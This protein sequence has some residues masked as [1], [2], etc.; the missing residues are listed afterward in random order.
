M[1]D[2]DYRYSAFISYRHVE[3]DMSVAKRLHTL[4]ETYRI[5]GAVRASSG[6]KKMGRVFRDQEELPLSSDLGGDITR[7]LEDS[8]WLIV[9]C[10][11]AL[12][13]SKWCMKEIDT[14]I[15][16][17][18]RDHILAVLAS[19]APEES[20]PP[21]LRF[22]EREG[23]VTEVEPLAA[24]IA[25]GGARAMLKKLRGES[26]R[27]LAPMLGVSY[28]DLKQ[29]ARERRLKTVLAASLAAFALLGAF[30]LYAVRQNRIVT[31]Q[32][33]AALTSQSLYLADASL[34]AEESGDHALALLLALEALPEDMAKPDRPVV[35]EAS[36]ALYQLLLAENGLTAGDSEYSSQAIVTTTNEILDCTIIHSADDER[37]L[38][39][40]TNDPASYIQD[41]SIATGARV[42][43]FDNS[44]LSGKPDRTKL[45]ESGS[46]SAFYYGDRVDYIRKD[47]E[48]FTAPLPER[49]AADREYAWELAESK[50]AWS[51]DYELFYRSDGSYQDNAVLLI[52]GDPFRID[53][54]YW[55]Y[56]AVPAATGL[57]EPTYLL[58]GLA[59]GDSLANLV[60]WNAKTRETLRTYELPDTVRGLAA[61]ADG[62]YYLVSCHSF[63]YDRQRDAGSLILGRTQSGE[64]LLT[65]DD[66]ALDGSVAAEL[67]FPQAEEDTYF[68]VVTQDGS[69]MVYDYAAMNWAFIHQAAGYRVLSACWSKDGESILAA[70]SDGCA[71]IVSMAGGVTAELPCA[72]SLERA[73]Y[74]DDDGLILLESFN[75]VQIYAAKEQ[76]SVSSMVITV[77]KPLNDDVSGSAFSP[78]GSLLALLYES[79]LLRVVDPTDGEIVF[80]DE[81]GVG[82]FP[83]YAGSYANMLAFSPDGGALV[84][85]V[86]ESGNEAEDEP[87]TMRVMDTAAWS[88]IRDFTPSYE[89]AAGQSAY[90]N[91]LSI[92]FNADGSLLAAVTQYGSSIV[93]VYDTA[94]WEP[95]WSRG[96]SEKAEEKHGGIEPFGDAVDINTIALFN[97]DGDM[98]LL[99]TYAED[100]DDIVGGSA[101]I[102]VLDAETGSA[103][104]KAPVSGY[105]RIAMKE[106]GSAV[107]WSLDK[108]LWVMAADGTELFATELPNSVDDGG[109]RFSTTEGYVCCTC[110]GSKIAADYIGKTVTDVSAEPTDWNRLNLSSMAVSEYGTLFFSETVNVNGYIYDNSRIEIP[111]GSGSL[112]LFRNQLIDADTG[113]PFLSFGGDGTEVELFAVS[114]D[115]AKLCYRTSDDRDTKILNLP[116][117]TDAISGARERLGGRE[118]SDE[119]MR[120][121]FI[122]Q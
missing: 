59:G 91:S 96:Y 57:D 26:L 15:E 108:R 102:S 34:R 85:P 20:F 10:S 6:K 98:A 58:G 13:E 42:E 117:L 84:Y 101:V 5:P 73:S 113:K 35:K 88:A 51:L 8:E 41:Y 31:E 68:S 114:P 48:A 56:K 99:D 75:A 40:F 47:G 78:D 116:S 89:Y 50:P 105:D 79:G 119:D 55:I 94:T 106:D 64:A 17:G 74:A 69:L 83:Y 37:L 23:R 24:D 52:G 12:L 110:K 39:I 21:Q 107:C 66:G 27:I 77:E 25:A 63:D 4:I 103:I 100:Y 90:L 54:L 81:T 111:F 44:R 62:A 76:E 38:R 61:S 121:Y 3:P 95:L 2:S 92:T 19:G 87:T 70:C 112:Y 9:I 32:K 115:G 122:I 67:A 97:K 43:G 18:R 30:S 104:S 45:L 11:P 60:L 33:N 120:T 46:M 29:R 72:N 49:D 80:S 53:E 93:A 65:L 86:S 36:N 14:F 22:V 28:D 71:R 118:L 1:G 109:L 7:A 82:N 16:L